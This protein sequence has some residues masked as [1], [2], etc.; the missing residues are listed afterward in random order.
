MADSD[1]AAGQQYRTRAV[2]RLYTSYGTKGATNH[3][4]EMTT[5]DIEFKDG[6]E[7]QKYLDAI[8][9]K[10]QPKKGQICAR[11]LKMISKSD[12]R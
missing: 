7:A 3:V 10:Y 2:G 6:V 4:L 5:R 11:R 1:Y 12:E 9:T 8:G